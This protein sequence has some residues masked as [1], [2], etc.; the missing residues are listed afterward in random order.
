MPADYGDYA[1]ERATAGTSGQMRKDILALRDSAKKVATTRPAAIEA[2]AAQNLKALDSQKA[3]EMKSLNEQA[4]EQVLNRFRNSDQQLRA[5][6]NE[7]STRIQE[8]QKHAKDIEK[9]GTGNTVARDTYLKVAA[10]LQQQLNALHTQNIG[11][12]E[13]PEATTQPATQPAPR[14][15]PPKI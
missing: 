10:L 9:S 4:A 12:T 2:N 8:M 13:E 11:G 7:L 1:A 14:S 5:K 3:A 15:L 6:I